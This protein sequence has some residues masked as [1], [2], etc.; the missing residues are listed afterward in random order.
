M[1]LKIKNQDLAENAPTSR[2]R[3]QRTR[4]IDAA[5]L[6]PLSALKA[7]GLARALDTTLE[8]LREAGLQ[9]LTGTIPY[10]PWLKVREANNS[11]IVS[12]RLVGVDADS[13][14]VAFEGDLLKINATRAKYRERSGRKFLR[15]EK[16][17]RTFERT[18]ALPPAFARNCAVATF[19]GNVL[20]IDVPRAGAAPEPVAPDS[21]AR[22][23][24]IADAGLEMAVAGE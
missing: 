4:W 9:L 5:T 18:I 21:V 17:L 1:R 16:T 14:D 12:T 8:E 6:R 7:I 19:S 24:A 20:R 10:V 2:A 3:S 13:I 11:L 22:P 15:I 23:A